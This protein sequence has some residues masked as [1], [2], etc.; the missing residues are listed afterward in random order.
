MEKNR[1]SG[2]YAPIDDQP[3][4]CYNSGALPIS[5][6]STGCEA[7]EFL[8]ESCV[9]PTNDIDLAE[10]WIKWQEGRFLYCNTT[11]KWMMWDGA[12]WK[13][14][15]RNEQVN[16]VIE[17]ARWMS[18]AAARNEIPSNSGT[19]LKSILWLGVLYHRDVLLKTA[20]S[21]P[22][23]SCVSTDFDADDYLL[24]LTNCALD[25]KHMQA[26]PRTRQM[27]LTR[28]MD[29]AFDGRATCPNWERMIYRMFF[30]E[31]EIISY[32]QKWMG[33]MLT[34]DTSEQSL[35]FFYGVSGSGKSR[36]I[37]ALLNMFGT[38][39]SKI[40]SHILL[41]KKND[42]Q[43]QREL[44]RMRGLR[45]VISNEIAENG[46]FDDTLIK[47]MTGSDTLTARE[48]YRETYT[49]VPK[50]KL[51]I[52]GNA[53]PKVS[54]STGLWR[55]LKVFPCNNTYEG[56]A[57][58]LPSSE[59]DAIIASEFSGI[60]NW[61]LVGLH[62]WK[63]QGGLGLPPQQ[64]REVTT[65]YKEESDMIQQFLR[66]CVIIGLTDKTRTSLNTIYKGYLA[67]CNEIG[68][69]RPYSRPRFQQKLETHQLFP[70]SRESESDIMYE[71]IA[72]RSIYD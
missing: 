36:L 33:Y 13:P 47:D 65:A 6:V 29:V 62:A 60:L 69:R 9:R 58:N 26:V 54:G 18:S 12:I 51:V 59:V 34:A 68:A 30:G 19:I 67:W 37:Q 53:K 27:M 43:A 21:F 32:L 24:N 5:D 14:C 7:A 22:G 63:T 16:S 46:E 28:R 17:F 44:S 49:Y 15:T 8:K 25:L 48:L 3:L 40:P 72:L 55:R 23:L 38:Y 45:L 71:G 50:F 64:V 66:E 20:S 70:R 10:A 4:V 52:Y 42:D 11:G 1:S 39:A 35:A 31:A 57:D 41:N 2:L 56:K 61:A